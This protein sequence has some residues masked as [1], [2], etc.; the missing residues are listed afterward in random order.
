MQSLFFSLMPVPSLS[1]RA[2][3]GTRGRRMP[4]LA[5]QPLAQL[6]EPPCPDHSNKLAPLSALRQSERPARAAMFA[7]SLG[8]PGN[9]ASVCANTAGPE[10][11]LGLARLHHFRACPK[12]SVIAYRLPLHQR[13]FVPECGAHADNDAVYPEL[14]RDRGQR[15][16]TAGARERGNSRRRNCSAAWLR[17]L[18]ISTDSAQDLRILAHARTMQPVHLSVDI[19]MLPSSGDLSC[20]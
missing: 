12:T 10:R 9:R 5:K 20:I 4:R 3:F 13:A 6:R 15:T 8:T 16:C 17:T 11:D 18:R 14:I 2:D 7:V 1:E 19:Y